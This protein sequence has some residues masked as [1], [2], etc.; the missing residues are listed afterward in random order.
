MGATSIFVGALG[1]LVAAPLA[2]DR[3]LSFA[4]RELAESLNFVPAIVFGACWILVSIALTVGVA[5]IF[6]TVESSSG[7][8]RRRIVVVAGAMLLV[9]AILAGSLFVSGTMS[10]AI[11]DTGGSPSVAAE[12]PAL[13]IVWIG[14]LSMI[15]GFLALNLAAVSIPTKNDRKTV[16]AAHEPHQ[17]A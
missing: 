5:S 2:V 16:H 15:G 4:Y 3:D 6:H 12:L 11:A 9:G 14:V 17:H 8:I 13:V 7:T 10:N 1:A